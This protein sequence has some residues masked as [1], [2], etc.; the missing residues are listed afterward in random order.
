[1]NERME[2]EMIRT[3]QRLRASMPERKKSASIH[4]YIA[5]TGAG[6]NEWPISADA[7]CCFRSFL[8]NSGPLACPTHAYRFLH[9]T[10]ANAAALSPLCATRQ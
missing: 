3:I 7:A 8:C 6:G 1:M 2:Q 10:N 5:K 4:Q 9:C